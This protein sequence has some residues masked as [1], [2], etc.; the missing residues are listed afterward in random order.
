[1]I[2]VIIVLAFLLSS[3]R[4]LASEEKTPSYPSYEYEVARVHEI[5]PHRRT[6]PLSGVRPGFNQLHLT[7][8]V[9]PTGD[10]L[11]AEP[12]GDRDTLKFWPQ[13]EDEVYQ[14]K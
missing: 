2:R 14:W 9:S 12:N 7:L 1:M 10:V 5:K 4:L 6:F 13:L 8:T 3:T 11:N